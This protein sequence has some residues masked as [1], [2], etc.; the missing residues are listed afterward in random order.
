MKKTHFL[1]IFY[2]ISSLSITTISNL[3]AVLSTATT[4]SLFD[5]ESALN[6]L[7]L[8]LEKLPKTYS[9]KINPNL[10]RLSTSI[11]DL[12]ISLEAEDEN[13]QKILSQIQPTQFEKLRENLDS[14]N[15]G[16]EKLINRLLNQAN[17]KN[18]LGLDWCVCQLATTTQRILLILN[19]LNDILTA[20]PQD[21]KSTNP[22]VHVEFGEEGCLQSYLLVLGL[23]KIGYKNINI[24]LISTQKFLTFDK[25]IKAI[26]DLNTK[27]GTNIL[28]KTYTNGHTDYIKDVRAKKANP[29][30]ILKA[31]S[32]GMVDPLVGLTF[33]A[34][35]K[36]QNLSISISNMEKE[37]TP[38]DNIKKANLLEC[39]KQGKQA[40]TL[41][42]FSN[43]IPTSNPTTE[44]F[45]SVVTYKNDNT[46]NKKLALQNMYRLLPSL[47]T[48]ILKENSLLAQSEDFLSTVKSARTD[49]SAVIYTLVENNIKKYTVEDALKL[50]DETY[51]AYIN[52]YNLEIKILQQ[53][54]TPD[55][56]WKFIIQL[57]KEIFPKDAQ[58]LISKI[59]KFEGYFKKQETVESLIDALNQVI[60]RLNLDINSKILVSNE[61]K[62]VL[63][64]ITQPGWILIKDETN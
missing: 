54:I 38:G 27:E 15:S 44:E 28:V 36:K 17:K 11:E 63:R 14:N 43:Y 55:R 34:H 10:E 22:I 9:T 50:I 13:F 64:I 2:I 20:Y 45:N 25:F 26:Q 33:L 61:I 37:L 3:K 35:I 1:L 46:S 7:T 41:N 49:N 8:D 42:L 31:N 5:L 53:T 47:Q 60:N 56:R 51:K 57:L 4:K 6:N 32:F 29:K 21:T 24:I 48:I 12:K 30:F 16:I 40:I 62:N 59:S 19:Q 58:H 39:S 18:D 23:V 52:P